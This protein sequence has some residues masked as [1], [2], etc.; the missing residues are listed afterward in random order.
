MTGEAVMDVLTNLLR[1]IPDELPEELF[2]IL[3]QRENLRI[4]RIVSRGHTSPPEGW[5]DQPWNEWVMLVRG[6]AQLR[7]SDGREVNLRAGDCIDIPAHVKHRVAW[8]DPDQNTVW[9]AVHTP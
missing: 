5:Y 8:T 1:G 3:V 4:E 6:A 9:L 2:E 7:F